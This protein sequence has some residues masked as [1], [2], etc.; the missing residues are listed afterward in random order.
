MASSTAVLHALGRCSV[1]FIEVVEAANIAPVVVTVRCLGS[2]EFEK[3]A[4]V[5]YGFRLN[6]VLEANRRQSSIRRMSS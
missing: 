2:T 3:S 1:L 4:A 6:R 5:L